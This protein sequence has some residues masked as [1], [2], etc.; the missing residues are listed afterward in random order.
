MSVIASRAY[1]W[2]GDNFVIVTKNATKELAARMLKAIAEE[3][4]KDIPFGN[5]EVLPMKE[6][7]PE[8][9]IPEEVDRM[10]TEMRTEP[11]FPEGQKYYPGMTPTQVLEQYGDKGFGNL[12]FL[13]KKFQDMPELIEEISMAQHAFM[14]K[15]FANVAPDDLALSMEEEQCRNFL[16]LY[17]GI[18]SQEDEKKVLNQAGVLDVKA[19]IAE[20]SIDKLRA[21]I[22]AMLN[23]YAKA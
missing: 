10:L 9:T 5:A 3:D 6:E 8:T 2:D 12:T 17:W 7:E 23:K 4:V 20:A 11:T 18:L 22:V 21:V 13:A 14:K 1:F 16:K 15:A 19:F